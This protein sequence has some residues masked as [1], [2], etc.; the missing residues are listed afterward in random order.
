MVINDNYLEMSLTELAYAYNSI[1]EQGSEAED[2]AERRH[3][4]R[5]YDM[6]DAI[7]IFRF[8]DEWEK[9]HTEAA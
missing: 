6:I 4:K 2:H 9:A 1:G 5:L 8:P 3:L 7:G